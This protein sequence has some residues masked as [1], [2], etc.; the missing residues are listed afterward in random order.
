MIKTLQTDKKKK[1]LL[2]FSREAVANLVTSFS[3][4][5][6][7]IRTFANMFDD[8]EPF[9]MEAGYLLHTVLKLIERKLDDIEGS[10]LSGTEGIWDVS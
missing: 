9:H 10:Q 4:D 6:E 3:S 5:E 7:T 1:N 2:S 8:N